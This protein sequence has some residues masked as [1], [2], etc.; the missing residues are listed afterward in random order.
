[1][2]NLVY[3]GYIDNDTFPLMKNRAK[4]AQRWALD[5]PTN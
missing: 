4:M 2:A 1:M 3:H 5:L